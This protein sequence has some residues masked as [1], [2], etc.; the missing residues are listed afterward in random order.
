MSKIIHE[1]FLYVDNKN[2]MIS[3]LPLEV[4]GHILTFIDFSERMEICNFLI[5]TGTVKIYNNMFITYMELLEESAR[6]D[7]LN[8]DPCFINID[9]DE[10]DA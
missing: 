1:T 9:T 2:I 5:N 7:R 8:I 3:N 6:L 4:W 10:L